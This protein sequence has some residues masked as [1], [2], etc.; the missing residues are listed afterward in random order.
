MPI[1]DLWQHF[2]FSPN[3]EQEEAIR[4]IKGPL[5]IT[6]GPGS[7]KTRVL[8]WRT[9]NLIVYKGVSPDEIFLSTFTEKAAKQLKDGLLNLLGFVT[10][11]T[12]T[13]YD[14]SNMAI[15]TVHS[16][17]QKLITDRRFSRD[18][19][20]P[21]VPRLMDELSQYFY[22]NRNCW[23][24][25]M[26]TG[27]FSKHEDGTFREGHQFIN[28]YVA[29]KPEYG[30]KHMAVLNAI[31]AFNRFSEESLL[32]Y[33]DSSFSEEDKLMKEIYQA[34]CQELRNGRTKTDFAQLQ[35]EAFNVLEENASSE[36]IFKYVIVDEYQDTNTIQEKLFFKLAAGHHNFCVVGDDDQALY[37]FR[38]ATVENLVEFADRCERYLGT[39]AHRVNLKVNYRSR[40]RIVDLYTGF[41]L[42]S[43]WR[44]E[45]GSGYYRVMDKKIEA[46]SKDDGPSV[47]VTD[48]GDEKQDVYDLVARKI[49]ELKEQGIITDYNQVAFLFPSLKNM[50]EPNVAVREIKETL[51]THGIQV[52]APRAG[53]FIQVVEALAV[54]GLIAKVFNTPDQLEIQSH[55][56]Q[57]FFRWVREARS[58]GEVLLDR[59][60]LLKEFV[61]IKRREWKEKMTDYETLATFFTSKGINFEDDFDPLL[62]R[63]ITEL[64]A[65]SET[66]KR[67]L[68]RVGFQKLLRRRHLANNPF[69]VR[70][71]INRLTS[72]DWSLLDLFY[73]LM[74]FRHFK[75]MF[76]LAEDGTD[77][78]PICNLALISGYLARYMDEYTTLITGQYLYEKKFVNVFFNSFCYALFRLGESEYE[79]ADDPFPKGRIPFLTIHQA[80]GLE[81]PVVVMGNLYKRT[82][83]ADALEANVREMTQMA[84]EPLDR[85]PEFDIMRLFYVGLSRAQ[86]LLILLEK[87]RGNVFEH[88]KFIRNLNLPLLDTLEIQQIPTASVDDDDIGKSYSYTGDYLS[89]LR[90]P[91]YYMIFRKYDFAPSRS[92]SMFFGSL[93]HRTIEDLH[94][95]LIHQKQQQHAI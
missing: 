4:H 35:H 27:E 81:F 88:L 10:N 42:Q 93:V 85:Y 79:D 11:K 54:F 50:G 62:S 23:D 43:N 56:Y 83:I 7:G 48:K 90:C 32:E 31:R 8:L 21:T 22:V 44:K 45:D 5:M 14:L 36:K 39:S 68:A 28:G 34:Y 19:Q 70:Y 41:M 46:N 17:C 9:V 71:V 49:V 16:I 24:T 76:D 92:Q 73:Q 95:Y 89:F 82:R 51:E 1:Q 13:P 26:E 63:E 86:N 75:D 38:G 80:K 66:A 6:A 77:E 64:S 53:R 91:R 57:S 59:D 33:D 69:N 40:K 72:L 2:N 47:F 3:D 55:N 87:K 67:T 20:R 84:G 94:L 60:P 15:G 78:G 12:G 37:R 30:S 58:F 18:G 29:D 52:Y 25:L 65:L 74:G 61:D